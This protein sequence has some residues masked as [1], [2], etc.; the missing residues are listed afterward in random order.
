MTEGRNNNRNG[1]LLVTSNILE[2]EFSRGYRGRL[3]VLNQYPSVLKFMAALREAMH[4]PGT[5]LTECS[6]AATLSLAAEIPVRDFVR[7]H[8][9]LPFHRTVSLKD[10]DVEHGDP[11]RLYLIDH[12]GTRVWRQSM[13]MF[14]PEC[15]VGDM[16]SPNKFA[17]WRRSHQLPGIPWCIK[18]GCQLANS[19]I[20]K[21]AFDDVPFPE[22]PANYG[23]SDKEFID[24][25][26]NPVIQ[27]YADIANAFLNSERPTPLIHATFRIAEQAKKHHLRVGARG[28]KPTLTDI[29][30]ERVPQYW[31]KTLYPDIENRLPGKFFN[32]ID[33]ITTGLVADQGYALSLAV[34]FDSS[35]EALNYWYADNDGLP[36]ER[37]VQRSFGKDYW[38][39][40]TMFKLYVEHRGNHTSIGKAL[41]IDPSYVRNELTAAGLPALGLV[42]MSATSLAILAFHAGMPLEAACESSG[43]SRSEVEKLIRGG[44]SKFSTA[45]KEMSQHEQTP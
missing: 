40:S 23:F 42:D 5:Q 33:N 11:S 28:Q 37:K 16:E 27:R 10:Y 2:D 12:F 38:N 15:V 36:Q 45:L 14:C 17:Y 35:T 39:S 13:A 24:V 6:A 8:S 31:I 3:R 18:H 25:T 34:L 22:L 20:G 26:L 29:V 9:L 21:K 19:S 4:P 41:E 30:L 32:P 44:I 1:S 7:K 43:A